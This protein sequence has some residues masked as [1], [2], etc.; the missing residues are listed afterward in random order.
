MLVCPL[1]L[2]TLILAV[3]EEYGGGRKKSVDRHFFQFK[4]CLN[5]SC[6]EQVIAPNWMLQQTTVSGSVCSAVFLF[7]MKIKL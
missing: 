7:A 4:E 5:S 3:P 6:V 2:D 1:L